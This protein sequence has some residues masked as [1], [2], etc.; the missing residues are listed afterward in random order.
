MTEKLQNRIPTIQD[1]F[2]SNKLSD[3][4]NEMISIRLSDENS[5]NTKNKNSSSDTTTTIKTSLASDDIQSSQN[6][7]TSSLESDLEEEKDK[8]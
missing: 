6:L 3:E 7:S 2:R 8:F 4:S 1:A 5:S